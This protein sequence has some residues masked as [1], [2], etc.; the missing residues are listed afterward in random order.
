[1]RAAFFE[2]I[3]SITV[4]ETEIPQ[5][6]TGEVRLRI[7]YCGICGS[8][9]TLYK[10]GA[11]SGP[12]A[13]LGH[14]VAAVVDLDPSG[15]WPD[16]SRVTQYPTGRGCGRCVWC[17]EG[18]FRYCT[19]PPSDARGGHGGGFAELMVVPAS[20][21]I[22][23]PDGVDDRAAA[24]AE[25]LGVALRAVE[26]ASPQV[27]DVAYVQGLGPLGLF[28]VAGLVAAGCSVVGSDPRPDRRELALRMGAQEVF[29][30]IE[31]EPLAVLLACHPKGPRVAFECSG[32]AE[33][34]QQVIEGCGPGGVVGILGIPFA[35]VSL[36]RMTLKD[37][38]AF[39]IQGPTPDSMRRGLDLLLERPHVAGAVTSLVPLEDVRAAFEALANGAGGAKVLVEP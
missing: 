34:L 17:R 20:A 14:E 24:L 22:R 21:L 8:D 32:T 25:P 36:L 33:A 26:M 16:G 13:I 1:M 4:R 35:P 7:R 11:L 30:P 31:V 2:G 38:R 18:R 3:R 23:V 9:L 29:D 37:L 28:A 10:T 27:G 39:S 15:T 5:P 19:D 6:R 12:N